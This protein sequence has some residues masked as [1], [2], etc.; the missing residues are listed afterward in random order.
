MPPRADLSNLGKLQTYKTIGILQRIVCVFGSWLWKPI[1][2]V[3]G[4]LLR[5]FFILRCTN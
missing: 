3:Y 2:A 4:T 5:R 1:M